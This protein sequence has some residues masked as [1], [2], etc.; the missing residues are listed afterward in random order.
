MTKLRA[1]ITSQEKTPLGI[2]PY[3]KTVSSRSF[4]N[5][6]VAIQKWFYN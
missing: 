3:Y 4:I 6:D 1:G 2:S 5:V